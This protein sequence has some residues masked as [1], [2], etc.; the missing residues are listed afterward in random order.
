MSGYIGSDGSSLAGALTPGGVVA[1]LNLDAQGNLKTNPLPGGNLVTNP[2][3]TEDQLRAWIIAGQCFS[4]AFTQSSGET[5]GN[6]CFSIFN[7]AA[8]G[9][10]IL[11]ISSKLTY[12]Y[13]SS[14]SS[15]GII[16]TTTD[17]ALLTTVTPINM[18]AG[19]S[20]TSIASVTANTTEIA[21]WPTGTTFDAGMVTNQEYFTNGAAILLPPGNGLAEAIYITIGSQTMYAYSMKWVEF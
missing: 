18:K 8:S 21:A 2:C 10:N 19:S 7:P 20:T 4:G 16:L 9:K 17:P 13:A 14:N 12:N 5:T 15:G 6:F 1:S 3:I 11:I